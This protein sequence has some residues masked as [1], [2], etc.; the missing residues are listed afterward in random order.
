MHKNAVYS[1]LND[2]ASSLSKLY[3]HQYLT[4]RKQPRAFREIK[5]K[6]NMLLHVFTKDTD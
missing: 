1:V 5:H 3:C 2:T 4:F 6:G